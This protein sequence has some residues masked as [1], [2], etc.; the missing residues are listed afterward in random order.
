MII[1]WNGSNSTALALWKSSHERW[2]L[3]GRKVKNSLKIFLWMTIPVTSA[4]SI[5]SASAPTTKMPQLRGRSRVKWK[6]KKKL[7]P[8]LSRT[9]MASPVRGSSCTVG[10][11]R[12]SPVDTRN[13]GE[14]S[15]G[16]LMPQLPACGSWACR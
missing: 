8:T 5:T 10:P 14:R 11:W 13:P 6:R 9:S 1:R 16:R 2:P 3:F 12:R 4:A 15:L 7:P